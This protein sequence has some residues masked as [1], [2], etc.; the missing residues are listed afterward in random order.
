MSLVLNGGLK[1]GEQ[2]ESKKMC[3]EVVRGFTSRKCMI[4]LFL[5]VAMNMKDKKWLA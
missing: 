5:T 3:E 4:V 2:Y 1:Q